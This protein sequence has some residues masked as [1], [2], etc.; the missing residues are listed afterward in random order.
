MLAKG[1]DTKD[2]NSLYYGNE[3]NKRL[4]F[5]WSENTS[6]VIIE[7]PK[8]Q[9]TVADARRGKL[10]C[11]CQ[12]YEGLWDERDVQTKHDGAGTLYVPARYSHWTTYA[13]SSR[14][15]SGKIPSV[16]IPII[17]CFPLLSSLRQSTPTCSP[18]AGF[19]HYSLPLSP[20]H[21]QAGQSRVEHS[22][23]SRSLQILCSDWFWSRP[24]SGPLWF[25]GWVKI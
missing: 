4:S 25:P 9:T 24:S 19:S 13:R 12:D 23:W 20:C 17:K 1:P 21:Y 10:R 14:T 5:G 2:E 3:N 7:M 22:H 6:I 18:A 11:S 8:K 15:L 16:E